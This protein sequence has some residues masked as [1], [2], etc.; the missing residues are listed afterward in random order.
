MIKVACA[1]A[2]VALALAWSGA[3]VAADAPKQM[4]AEVIADLNG[5]G[6]KDKAVL[7]HD[8]DGEDVD[9][10]IYLS[11]G[12]KPSDKPAAHKSAFGWTG[13]MAGTKPELG[14][15]KAGSLVVV[16]QN[17]GVGRDRWR[18]QFTIAL[19][20]GQL[21]VAGYD[22]ESR[23]TLAPG[24]SGN[25]DIDFLAGKGSRNGKPVKVPAGAV[26]LSDWSDKS[27]P[28]ACNFD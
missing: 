15:N 3:V 13:D 28:A 11:G 14:T 5:D 22:Y 24:H 19:R 2:S 4:L 17:D 10:A 20:G 23:D 6:V 1:F 18:Q 8:K 21:V 27:V 7:L 25:C 16:F 9:L 12:G 26:P